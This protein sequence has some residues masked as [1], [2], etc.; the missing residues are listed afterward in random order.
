[1]DL[2]RKLPGVTEANYRGLM[3][4]AGS[5][6]GLADMPVA[7]LEAAMGSARNAKALREFLDAPCPRLG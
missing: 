7:A 1:M 2:L 5:L 3:A 4:A 6:A